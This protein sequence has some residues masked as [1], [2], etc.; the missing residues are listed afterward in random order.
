MGGER[1]KRKPFP[2]WPQYGDG[3]RNA[4]T[5]VLESGVWWRTPGTRTLAFEREFAKFHRAKHGMAVTNG[6]A[7]LEVSMS[8]PGVGPGDARVN[9]PVSTC[10]RSHGALQINVATLSLRNK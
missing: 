3:E 7:A 1:T 10:I 6:T 9:C 5:E 2:I 4:L 8:A